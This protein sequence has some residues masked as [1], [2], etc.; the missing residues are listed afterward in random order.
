MSNNP[1]KN[2]IPTQPQ[3]GRLVVGRQDF[4]AHI[5]GVPG[6]NNADLRHNADAIDLLND[7]VLDGYTY[8][9]VGDAIQALGVSTNGPYAG[10]IDGYPGNRNTIT[11]IGIQGVPVTRPTL[12]TGNVLFATSPTRLGFGPLPLSI[13]GAV[14]GI[15]PAANQAPQFMI[16]DAYGPTNANLIQQISGYPYGNTVNVNA[17]LDAY[18]PITIMT[19]GS[20]VIADTCSFYPESVTFTPETTVLMEGD[21]TFTGNSIVSFDGIIPPA[22]YSI[23]TPGSEFA[24][25]LYSNNVVKAWA[26]ITTPGFLS[27][28]MACSTFSNNGYGSF[29]GFSSMYYVNMGSYDELTF[30]FT[31]QLIT[32][33]YCIQCFINNGIDSTDM[34]TNTVLGGQN[35]QGDLY[36]IISSQSGS[37]FTINAFA[38]G[39]QGLDGYVTQNAGILVPLTIATSIFVVVLGT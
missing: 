19:T 8:T 16:G 33:T 12:A 32:S 24:N 1:P 17:P 29:F 10:D 9:N 21:V 23:S 37:S 35:E 31:N 2:F 6:A 20:L 13:S 38:E 18:A 4:Q 7:L 15:L 3:Q 27:G 22:F 25:G 26:S 11:V 14:T 39:T 34:T 30:Y 28:T 36:P 5:Q